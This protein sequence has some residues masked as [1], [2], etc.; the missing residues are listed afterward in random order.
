M[1]KISFE[2][3]KITQHKHSKRNS[4]KFNPAIM[5]LS[6]ILKAQLSHSWK[7]NNTREFGLKNTS[8][9]IQVCRR[10]SFWKQPPRLCCCLDV[11]F[12]L[13]LTKATQSCYTANTCHCA[14]VHH[15]RASWKV[16][17]QL[18]CRA[19]DDHL[20]PF[21]LPPSTQYFMCLRRRV[22]IKK[23]T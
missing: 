19:A 13:F 2:E 20:P 17:R 14:H 9:C 1:P 12:S 8:L 21:V 6:K 23:H 3:T 22:C 11:Q 18:I 7:D 15:P 4:Q 16:D 10:V 5:V